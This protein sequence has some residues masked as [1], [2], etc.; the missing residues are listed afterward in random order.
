MAGPPWDAY[1]SPKMLKTIEHFNIYADAEGNEFLC[2]MVIAPGTDHKCGWDDM[3]YLGEVVTHVR[4]V[5][6]STFGNFSIPGN[7]R[8]APLKGNQKAAVTKASTPAKAIND[9]VCPACKNDKCSKTEKSC[10][11]CGFQFNKS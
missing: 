3:V 10:W 11:K 5:R 2:T 6:K 1:Y 9:Y 7:V 4:Y 8:T